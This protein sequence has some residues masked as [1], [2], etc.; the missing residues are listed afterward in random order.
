MVGN[1]LIERGAATDSATAPGTL[2]PVFVVVPS[3]K[4]PAGEVSDFKIFNQTTLGTAPNS[5]EGNLFHAYV[6]RPDASVPNKYTVVFDS[7]EQTVPAPA[8]GGE[9]STFTLAAPVTVQQDDVIGFYGEGVPFDIG[10]AT[11]PDSY[12][13][14]ASADASMTT[15]AAPAQGDTMTLGTDTNY[16]LSSQDRTYSFAR[17][18]DS[19]GPRQRRYRC[20]DRGP[21]DRWHLLDRGDGRRF[22]A[23]PARRS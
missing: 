1:Q 13:T 5:S 23:T 6:L 11:N 18:R 21:Q 19:R 22:R 2:G 7:G 15:N 16:P 8:T 20:R 4:L 17:H 10:T 14:P 9:V 12:S 3:A